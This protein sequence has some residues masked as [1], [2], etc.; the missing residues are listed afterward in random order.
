MFVGDVKICAHSK[1]QVEICKDLNPSVKGYIFFL[2]R[3]THQLILILLASIKMANNQICE[4]V[5]NSDG[6]QVENCYIQTSTKTLDDSSTKERKKFFASFKKDQVGH[7]DIESNAF[8]CNKNVDNSTEVFTN[9]VL[10]DSN[11]THSEKINISNLNKDYNCKSISMLQRNKANFLH[12]D[13]F[14]CYTNNFQDTINQ[15]RRE[16]EALE[17]A[18]REAHSTTQNNQSHS[19]ESSN[20]NNESSNVNNELANE[21]LSFNARQVRLNQENIKTLF[22]IHNNSPTK[23]FGWAPIKKKPLS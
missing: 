6:S 17:D 23:R 10:G 12:N 9:C 20:V 19:N 14:T 13:T 2:L 22:S 1:K 15:K 5:T 3:S 21:S 8:F 18:L 11:K 16:R 7:N 4:V